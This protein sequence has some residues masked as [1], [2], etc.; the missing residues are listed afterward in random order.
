M[1]LE[2]G[3]AVACY[4][5]DDQDLSKP[6]SE[7]NKIEFFGNVSYVRSAIASQKPILPVVGCGGGETVYTLNSGEKIARKLRLDELFG[8]RS[9]PTFWSFPRG[10]HAGHTPHFSIPM[11]T[12]IILSVL[13]PI[14]TDGFSPE[15]ADNPEV[16][17][18][19]D[20]KIRGLM[21][22]ELDMLTKGRIPVI[23]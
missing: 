4:P 18:M 2:S 17:K 9:W 12:K 10:L 22:E 14:P 6:F 3:F 8:I 1:A 7:R 19:L 23:G 13:P 15:D 21:Q 11:P 20:V 16:V 5:G